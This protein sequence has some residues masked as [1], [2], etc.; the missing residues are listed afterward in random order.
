MSDKINREQLR[1]HVDA[2]LNNSSTEEV[3]S[4]DYY[5]EWDWEEPEH[6]E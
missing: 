1:K 3:D 5:K 6:D 2:V 4:D